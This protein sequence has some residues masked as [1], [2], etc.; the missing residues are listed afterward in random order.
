[1]RVSAAARLLS[2]QPSATNGRPRPCRD[3]RRLSGRSG[4]V[5]LGVKDPPSR[6]PSLP[7]GGDDQL[8]AFRRGHSGT[9]RGSAA[10]P[11]MEPRLRVE[12][13]RARRVLRRWRVL[14]HSGRGN[15]PIARPS[16][17]PRWAAYTCSE[18]VS[19]PACFPPNTAA[20]RWLGTWMDIEEVVRAEYSRALAGWPAPMA[21]DDSPDLCDAGAVSAVES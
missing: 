15:E 21:A 14:H 3:G 9:A 10:P 6:Q 4:D 2:F 12:L 16:G 19:A 20:C 13:R 1:M 18:P 8:R 5:E 17:A 7:P 11:D